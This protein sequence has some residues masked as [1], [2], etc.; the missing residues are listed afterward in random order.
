MELNKRSKKFKIKFSIIDLNF[1]RRYLFRVYTAKNNSTDPTMNK[2][3][4]A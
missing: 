4:G 3:P 1:P 2:E